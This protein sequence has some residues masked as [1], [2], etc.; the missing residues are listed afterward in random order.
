M[1]LAKWIIVCLVVWAPQR[2]W[3]LNPSSI[4]GSWNG[5]FS[6][7]G[8]VQLVD[9]QFSRSGDSL[10]GRYDIPEMGLY[11]EP[12]KEISL[13]DSV[14][15]IRLLYGT[16]ALVVH[17][18]IEQM[19]ALNDRWNPPVSL[20][21]KKSERVQEVALVSEPVTF[22]SEGVK[23]AGTFV[24]PVQTTPCPALVAIPGSGKQGRETW[25]Y[26]SHAYALARRGIAVLLYDKRGV[27]E[28]QGELATAD[29][30][31]LARDAM[32]ALKLVRERHDVEAA[33][34]GFLGI[35]QGGWIAAITSK[36]KEGPD[37]MVFLEGPAVTLEKQELDRVAYS[38]RADGQAQSAIDSAVSHTHNYFTVVNTSKG[39]PALEAST[40]AASAAPWAEYVNLPAAP[41]DSDI[42][43]WRLNQYDPAEDLKRLRCPV[44]AV[45]GEDDCN[46]PPAEN[47]ELMTQYLS[48]AGV[49]YQTAIIPK[50]PHSV[51]TYQTLKGGEWEWPHGF[52]VW[53]RRPASLDSTIATWVLAS[54]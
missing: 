50:L 17:P 6:R 13:A 23:L 40:K 5:A 48:Q 53:S 37:F 27:G 43:W 9:V 34:V 46:V 4:V 35:S 14:L 15:S 8:S 36:W 49:K 31:L 25:E 3:A 2:L 41:D 38:M 18:Q 21:L 54:R 28:S 10:A 16:F 42:A 52:W 22:E 1:R 29:F 47:L 24:R 33:Q 30:T 45:F 20:H 19:T 51:T 7:L 26:R 12:L 39:W 44:L 32:A 11:E